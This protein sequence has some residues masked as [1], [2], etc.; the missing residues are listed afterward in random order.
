MEEEDGAG[1]ERGRHGRRHDFHP[2]RREAEED[3]SSEEEFL[4][5]RRSCPAAAAAPVPTAAP[6][7]RFMPVSHDATDIRHEGG[8]QEGFDADLARV[9]ELSRQEYEHSQAYQ[10]RR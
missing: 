1:P 6:A 3:E 9:L 7:P 2:Y 4:G 5:E 8:A 10:S